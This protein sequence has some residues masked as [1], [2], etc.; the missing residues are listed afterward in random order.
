MCSASSVLS[1]SVL[2]QG[3]VRSGAL[4]EFRAS[5]STPESRSFF[6]L[7]KTFVNPVLSWSRRHPVLLLG[8]LGFGVG[9]LVCYRFALFSRG[10]TAL[11]KFF[12]PS[13]E[14]KKLVESQQQSKFNI[15]ELP[16]PLGA[17]EL[18]GVQNK[19]EFKKIFTGK[20]AKF[21]NLVKQS[22][23]V[24]GSEK[25]RE[26]LFKEYLKESGYDREKEDM[27]YKN[28]WLIFCALA[29][30]Q[31]LATENTFEEFA[32]ACD[33]VVESEQPELKIEEKIEKKIEEK[34][35]KKK[36][37]AI[38]HVE[39]LKPLYKNEDR[40]AV[41]EKEGYFLSGVFDG[42]GGSQ[43]A[44]ALSKEFLGRL[45]NAI[46]TL[47]NLNDETA[48]KQKIVQVFEEQDA[49]FLKNVSKYENF[50][51]LDESL[52]E[53][54]GST[55]TVVIIPPQGEKVFVAYIGDSQ[56]MS[57]SGITH[58]FLGQ[59]RPDNKTE[60]KRIIEAARTSGKKIEDVL[61][62][63]KDRVCGFE[64]S[65]AFGDFS[66]NQKTNEWIKL[67]GIIATPEVQVLDRSAV[68]SILIGSDG[69]WDGL[70]FVIGRISEY[71]NSQ[72]YVMFDNLIENKTTVEAIAENLCKTAEKGWKKA[73]Q[74]IVPKESGFSSKTNDDVT[75][76]LVK[77]P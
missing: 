51:E 20:A 50:D 59:H 48:I 44:E 71:S 15:R 24:V 4:S 54:A 10:Y 16:E 14:E 32:R 67:T 75:V 25:E 35:E 49:D 38:Q 22:S 73:Q 47:P 70:A 27:V 37:S 60:E 7:N 17:I 26:E 8:G 45:Y 62:I 68:N 5:K 28:L 29:A 64:T 12:A 13:V 43:I 30:P 3:A 21:L 52:G 41:L 76:V 72:Y 23:L 58:F 9:L 77:L 18:C 61:S 63:K 39:C 1:A 69:L 33:V 55:A 57:V 74:G 31:L 34:I 66:F 53:T 19:P 6:S 36:L 46:S 65:R 40:F 42:H 2:Q 11:Q 56:A